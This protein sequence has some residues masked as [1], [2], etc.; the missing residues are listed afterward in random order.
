MPRSDLR[1]VPLA[2]P[3]TRRRLSHLAG[4]VAVVVG[5]VGDEQDGDRLVVVAVALPRPLH[6]GLEAVGRRG[7]VGSGSF[8]RACR[9]RAGRSGSCV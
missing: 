8:T 9:R 1:S 5:E 2:L 3:F 6:L 7:E 4:A